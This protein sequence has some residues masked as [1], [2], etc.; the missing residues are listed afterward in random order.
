M[1]HATP[2]VMVAGEALV[3]LMV[4]ENTRRPTACPGGSPA[5]TAIAIAR[6]GT[7]VTFACRFGDDHFGDLLLANLAAN[8]VDLSYAV[9][10]SEPASLAVVSLDADGSACYRFHVA[11]TA[12]WAWTEDEL[13]EELPATI[14]AV[15]TGSLAVAM[16]AGADALSAWFARQHA[17]RTTSFDP[18]IRP[19]LIGPRET[20]LPRLEAL[21]ATSD[22]VKVSTE[23]LGWV[24]PGED[25]VRVA[26]RWHR[27]L[28][29]RLIVVTLGG[30][31]AVGVHANGIIRRPASPVSIVDTVGAGDSFSGALL[32][33]L[34]RT[35]RL[36]RPR[37]DELTGA[38]LADALDYACVAAGLACT[39]EGADPPHAPEVD[40]AARLGVTPVA[41]C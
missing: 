9:E 21:V 29:P 24:C 14:E 38:E 8:G 5:N 23:D 1:T 32:H 7:P 12:D 16:G 2:R 19:G 36:A 25:P 4:G 18:N 20:Y 31:G 30:A 33:W 15:H 39:R 13:P 37:L 6:L 26:V 28:G 10:A 27:E 17:Q 40:A 3:D 22:I 35:N 11:D 34:A 41:A